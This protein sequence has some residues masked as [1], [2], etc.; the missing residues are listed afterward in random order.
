MSIKP[1]K[2]KSVA[3]KSQPSEKLKE[4]AAKVKE[5]ANRADTSDV[6]ERLRI[7]RKTV[8]RAVTALLDDA[9]R[10]EKKLAAEAK[11]DE[12][13]FYFPKS[14]VHLQ[15]TL[16]IAPLKTKLRPVAMYV[17][18]PISSAFLFQSSKLDAS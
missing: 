1:A 17:L 8:S 18:K 9:V 13:A 16:Q 14:T 3:L 7:S 2:V 4:P 5:N 12:G 11:G 10:H 6:F 15:F